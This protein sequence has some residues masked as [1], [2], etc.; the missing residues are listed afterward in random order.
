MWAN[1]QNTH[2]HASTHTRIHVHRA[3]ESYLFQEN[4]GY[5]YKRRNNEFT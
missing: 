1:P 2:T 5:E 4:I 3:A